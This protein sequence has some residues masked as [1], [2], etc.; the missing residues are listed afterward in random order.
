MYDL[1]T[2]ALS[3]SISLLVS[4]AILVA[5]L[6]PLRRVLALA[7]KGGEALPFWHSFTMVMLYAVPL[8]F[9]VIW[10]PHRQDPVDIARLALAASLF[11]AIGGLSV[12][13]IN[14]ANRKT[15]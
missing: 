12:I 4:T 5:I 11:G 13:G 6:R 15:G 1:S 2:F 8:F 10:M 9:T 7:C 3:V 14:V